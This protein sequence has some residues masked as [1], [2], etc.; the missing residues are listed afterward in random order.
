M[1]L[2]LDRDELYPYYYVVSN[3][4]FGDE[5]EVDD[6]TAWRWKSVMEDFKEIQGEM[7]VALAPKIEPKGGTE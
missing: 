1:K 2:F 6:E 3:P 7:K 5:V 4:R